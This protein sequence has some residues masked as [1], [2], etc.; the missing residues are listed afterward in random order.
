MAAGSGKFQKK[1]EKK[2]TI[3]NYYNDVIYTDKARCI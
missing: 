1:E 2:E 3:A